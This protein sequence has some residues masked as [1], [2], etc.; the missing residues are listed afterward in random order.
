MCIPKTPN[1]TFLAKSAASNSNS[2]FYHEL[3]KRIATEMYGN[4]C[5]QFET[6]CNLWLL[7]WT[8][9]SAGIFSFS[10]GVRSACVRFPPGPAYFLFFH[11]PQAH[12]VSAITAAARAGCSSCDC[13]R[14]VTVSSMQ[15]RRTFHTRRL[16]VEAAP[17]CGTG[18]PGRDC[19]CRCCSSPL[20]SLPSGNRQT[21]TLRES[22]QTFRI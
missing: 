7:V 13:A 14:G 15:A 21:R 12:P 3:S 16:R 4:S 18:S 20:S 5:I 6:N 11:R 2:E 22:M 10:H 17:V 8:G 9:A 19:R 1:T